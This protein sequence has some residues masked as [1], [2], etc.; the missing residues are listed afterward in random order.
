M[1]ELLSEALSADVAVA[2]TIDDFVSTDS[3]VS[4]LIMTYN[5]RKEGKKYVQDTLTKL[6]LDLAKSN[7]TFGSF[8]PGGTP[9]IKGL[10][11]ACDLFLQKILDTRDLLPYGLRYL[12]KHIYKQV[13]TKFQSNP[14]QLKNIWRA[15][16]YY[17]FYR[18]FLFFFS[19][20]IYF[21]KDM[22]VPLL[23]VLMFLELLILMVIQQEMKLHLIWLLFQK[24]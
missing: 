14:K 22:L 5:T 12:C 11:K 6:I 15:V 7:Q 10:T 21:F 13:H 9:D 3:V 18:Y 17:V 24:S 2:D 19:M 20:E 4:R 16:G 23:F 8:G 1:L